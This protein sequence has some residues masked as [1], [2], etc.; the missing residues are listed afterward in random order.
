MLLIR[1]PYC[2]DRPEVE[3]RYGGEAHIARAERPADLD[4][5]A[6][7]AF[8]YLRSNPKGPHAER[9]RHIHGCG[10]FFNA[11]RDTVSDKFAATYRIG[12]PRPDP[13][14]AKDEAS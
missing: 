2:G 14:A 13:A 4:D 12:E 6:W 11:L 8:L 1:C 10:R 9:W 7:V 5:R 3:F